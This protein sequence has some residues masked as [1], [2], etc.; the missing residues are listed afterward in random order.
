MAA[1]LTC[2]VCTSEPAVQ[3]MTNVTD[4][5]V[6]AL[7]AQCLPGFYGAS[8]LIMMDAGD[9][10]GPAGKCQA[11]R[12]FHERMTTPVTPIGVPAGDQNDHT[13]EPGDPGPEA[14]SQ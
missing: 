8:V 2:D 6:L 10:K 13:D 7:G 4:G 3:M 11:C 14:A 12:R 5:T 9:H 1:P